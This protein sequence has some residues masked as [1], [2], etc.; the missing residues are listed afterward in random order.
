MFRVLGLNSLICSMHHRVQF[1]SRDNSLVK[2][3]FSRDI[4]FQSSSISSINIYENLFAVVHTKSSARLVDDSSHKMIDNKL[5]HFNQH[6]TYISL[7][8]YRRFFSPF[9]L[10][11][12]CCNWIVLVFTVWRTKNVQHS[13][14]TRFCQ[15]STTHWTLDSSHGKQRRDLLE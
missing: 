5:I 8:F 15:R 7:R 1:T 2:L 13:A 10:S 3:S 14:M 4:V 11:A 6:W 12:D 9:S